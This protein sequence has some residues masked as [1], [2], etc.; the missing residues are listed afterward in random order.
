MSEAAV[1]KPNCI[2]RPATILPFSQMPINGTSRRRVAA[3]ARVSTDSEEQLTSYEVQVTHYTEYIQGRSDWL[4]AGMYADEGLSGLSTKNRKHFNQ[5]IADALAGKIDLIIVKSISRF[6]RNTL[7]TL[8]IVREL[9]AAGCEVFFEK[10]SLYSFDPKAELLLTIMSSLA[11]EESRSISENVTWGKRKRL[12]E[13]HFGLPYKQFLG[14]EKGPDGKPAIV[15]DEAV[16]VRQIYNLFLSGGTYNQIADHLMAA[17]IPSPG[18]KPKWPV[19]TVESILQN[20]KYKGD[21]ILQKSVTIDYLEKRRKWNDGEAA[22]YVHTGTHDAIIEPEVFDFVQ[23]E[24]ERRRA[25]GRSYSGKDPFSSRV[26]CG[27]C[28]GLYGPKV[29]CSNTKYRR[30]I[31]RCNR[32]YEKG[33]AVCSTPH[34]SEDEIKRAFVTVFNRMLA[35]KDVVL[36]ACREVVVMISDTSELEAAI[37]QQKEAVANLGTQIRALINRNAS[38]AQDQ[39]QYDAEYDALAQQY[40]EANAKLAELEAALRERQG[41]R[42]ELLAYLNLLEGTGDLVTEFDERLWN[43]VVDTVTV[44]GDGV[45]MFR[46]KDGRVIAWR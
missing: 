29:W 44:Q 18:G 28:G 4:F 38:M 27:E 26:V 43:L 15:E 11:Q 33:K 30:T 34:F 21:A 12:A 39:V 45:M 6:A 23:C 16:I 9:K 25:L 20:E 8:R 31:F 37:E 2:I 36:S 40:G 42:T 17:G 41:R 22:Q 3:Y 24:I 32:K 10:E 5:M 7:D 14:F 19:S 13:G 35:G 46:L 1:R